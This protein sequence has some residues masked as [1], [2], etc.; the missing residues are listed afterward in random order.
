[1]PMIASDADDQEDRADD[2][3]DL[4]RVG[5]VAA[6][7]ATR[8]RVDLAHRLPPDRPGERRQHQRDAA[9]EHDADQADDA[10]H[11]RGRGRRLV[12]QPRAVAGRVARRRAGGRRARRPARTGRT[13]PAAG[14]GSAA[15]GR[16][17]CGAAYGFCGRGVGV[18]RR[19]HGARARVAPYGVVGGGGASG[20]R[21]RGGTR[22]RL[23]LVHARAL[24]AHGDMVADGG[25]A[26]SQSPTSASRPRLHVVGRARR[27]HRHRGELGEGLVARGRGPR[28]WWRTA[29]PAASRRAAGRRRPGRWWPRPRAGVGSGTDVRSE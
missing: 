4:A 27:P 29:R 16:E 2:A 8:V 3:H 10:Q 24:V 17:L 13:S 9:A 28:A 14:R 7:V 22:D 21:R 5:L 19:R 12:G 20:G 26:D 11:H 23:R 15:A 25:G 6:G 18:L 1:M